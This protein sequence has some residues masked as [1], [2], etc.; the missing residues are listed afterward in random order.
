M[1]WQFYLGD[2]FQSTRLFVF[3]KIFEIIFVA[4]LCPA[5]DGLNFFEI[6]FIAAIFHKFVNNYTKLLLYIHILHHFIS[7]TLLISFTSTSM[8]HPAKWNQMDD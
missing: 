5:F 4:D 3:L 1:R 8:H 7:S 6:I 2:S